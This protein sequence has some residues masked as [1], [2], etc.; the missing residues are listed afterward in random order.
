MENAEHDNEKTVS[1]AVHPVA[2]MVEGVDKPP[3]LH[4][5]TTAQARS[6]SQL[7]RVA[8]SASSRTLII[9]D[10]RSTNSEQLPPFA[11][12]CH[13]PVR[14]SRYYRHFESHTV[15]HAVMM[16]AE[17]ERINIPILP[18]T[19][20]IALPNT[21]DRQGGWGFVVREMTPRPAILDRKTKLM[22]CFSL[23]GRDIH[24]LEGEPLLVKL[25]RHQSKK[26]AINYVLDYIM[27]P[28]IRNFCKAFLQ[29]GILLEAHGQNT[30]LA[31]IHEEV[32]YQQTVYYIHVYQH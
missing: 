20:G 9:L 11:V 22:P 7:M 29:L 28:I 32:Y 31:G 16:S 2:F 14:I 5:L 27:V 21:K 18:E 13:C 8:P 4:L 3:W 30:L 1:F 25:I 19:L 12:K 26:N 24:D 15:R 23:Y 10:P 6:E 17:L